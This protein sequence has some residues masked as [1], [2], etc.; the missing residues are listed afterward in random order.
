MPRTYPRP[1]KSDSLGE[2]SEYSYFYS[3]P[4]LK[5]TLV[6]NL[7]LVCLNYSP[8]IFFPAYV[9]PV[10]LAFCDSLNKSSLLPTQE[11]SLGV[12]LCSSH[13]SFSISLRSL[14][15]KHQ[16]CTLSRVAVLS[17]ILTYFDFLHSTYGSDMHVCASSSPIRT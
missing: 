7:A 10:P 5:I 9:T 12:Y 6:C 2:R 4:E 13:C 3:S 17:C 16:S 1:N 14:L 15:K 11:L 8:N